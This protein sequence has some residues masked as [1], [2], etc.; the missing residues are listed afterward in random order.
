MFKPT[1][2]MVPTDFSKSSIAAFK[3][4]V[5]LAEQFSAELHLI[6]V[7]TEMEHMPLFFL[8]DE[9]I[10]EL[11]TNVTEYVNTQFSD[12]EE[13]YAKGVKVNRVIR[14]GVAYDEILKASKELSIDLIVISSKGKNS[15]E[16]FFFG[17]TTEKVVRKSVASV[18]I[19]K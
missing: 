1:H 3:Q 2:I 4:A 18:L 19:V 15:L 8:D 5:E 12:I 9:K 10:K 13:K 6:H 7:K 17:S 11:N 14:E 16:E